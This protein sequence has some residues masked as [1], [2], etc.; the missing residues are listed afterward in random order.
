MGKKESFKE[1]NYVCEVCRQN[2]KVKIYSPENYSGGSNYS[3]VNC[4]TVFATGE[5]I[6]NAL[7]N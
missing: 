2:N 7:A 3:C 4:D 6:K 1:L 5:E